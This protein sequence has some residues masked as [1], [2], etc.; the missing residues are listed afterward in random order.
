[1]PFQ[2]P[3]IAE[4]LHL[5]Y[6]VRIFPGSIP[7][8]IVV[9]HEVGGS[10]HDDGCFR[11]IRFHIHHTLSSQCSLDAFL[12]LSFHFQHIS[13]GRCRHLVL[14]G[15]VQ[16]DIK[17]QHAL[18]TCLD[19]TYND[20]IGKRSKSSSFI[21]HAIEHKAGMRQ[22]FLQIKFA[23]VSLNLAILFHQ[24]MQIRHRQ[25]AHTMG[26]SE[27]VFIDDV[28]RLVFPSIKDQLAYLRQQSHRLAAI[29]IARP[30][31][32]EG[33]LIELDVLVLHTTIHHASQMGVAYRQCLQPVAG[34]SIIP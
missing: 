4:R 25:E 15:S 2:Q 18:F 8:H 34:R 17:C 27:E 22:G 21:L 20:P 12:V 33:F 6:I 30:T 29:V 5:I 11:P 26:T 9:V 7:R 13:I 23:M 3:G 32:P 31:A 1:M 16:F 24:N 10:T 14:E 19:M 28:C